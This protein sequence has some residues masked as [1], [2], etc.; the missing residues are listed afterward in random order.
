MK[1]VF[2]ALLLV[3]VTCGFASAAEILMSGNVG[4]GHY[5]GN[6]DDAGAWF[7][8]PNP[9]GRI[10]TAGDNAAIDRGWDGSSATLAAGSPE[11]NINNLTIA[12]HYK[13]NDLTIGAGVDVN[14]SGNLLIG[15]STTGDGTL[16][17]SGNI[18][19]SPEV[20]VGAYG[21]GTLNMNGGSLTSTYFSAP[22]WHASAASAPNQTTA[23]VQLDGGTIT[24]WDWKMLSGSGDRNGTMD[25]TG[26][27][28]I[29][30][31]GDMATRAQTYIDNGWLT[32]YSGAGNVVI[33]TSG[34]SGNAVVITGVVPEPA[35]LV[36][37][38]LASLALVVRRRK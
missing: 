21:N 20:I 31:R 32:A 11:V 30:T 8:H 5:V 26:G 7:I 33:D 6:W 34:V 23:H 4:G 2:A 29:G 37:L 10:P 15:G 1:K 28:L 27:M 16:H 25:I 22:S 38:S 19:A 9:A 3:V 13:N 36:L 14:L 17:N 35:S 24:A 18:T 12:Y